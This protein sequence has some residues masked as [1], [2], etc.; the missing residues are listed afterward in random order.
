[1]TIAQHYRNDDIPGYKT[2]FI[3]M[4]TLF[5]FSLLSFVNILKLKKPILGL[6]NIGF[7]TVVAGLYL[8]FGLYTLG[9][10]RE[11]YLSQVLSEYYHRGAFNIGIRYVS[12]VF[13]AMMLLALYKYVRQEFLDTDFRKEFDIFLH[14]AILTLAGNELINW[15]DLFRSQESYK[16]G[17]SILF[18][19]YSLLLIVLGI[20]KKKLHLRIGAIVLFAATLVK[21]FFYDL[22]Y[23]DTISKTIVFVVL[24]LLLLVISFLYNKYKKVI[25]EDNN[26]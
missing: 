14:L 4:Y 11:T 5:F 18:G 3:L 19:V 17:L 6:I 23:L 7:N 26:P 10:L 12:F 15:M 8:T 25:F 2:I 24:G 20:W 9:A 1:L 22:S 13:F 16:L 21:L